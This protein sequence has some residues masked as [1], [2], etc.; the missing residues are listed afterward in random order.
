MQAEKIFEALCEMAPLSLALSFDNSGFLIGSKTAEIKKAVVCLDC[1]EEVIDHA[2]NEGAN[3]IITHHP[4]IFNP[5]K[6]VTYEQNRK[7]Y[8]LLSGSL[9][10]ISMHTNLDCAIGGVNDCLAKA[11]GLGNI[12]AITDE[13]G[14]SLRQGEFESFVSADQLAELLKQKLGGNVRY[15][16]KHPEEK[17]IKR[18]AVCGGSG[19]NFIPFAFKNGADAFVTSEVKHDKF[20]F[21]ADNGLAVFDAGHYFTEQ[22]VV[23]PLCSYLKERFPQVLF[24]EHYSVDIKTI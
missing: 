10:L 5:L 14:F 23:K 20:I 11:I 17:T 21:A 8:R 12:T 2:I 15:V 7:I 13:E 9:N 3:L 24:S 22:T 4:V 18:V 19:G 1:T 16:S 6:S